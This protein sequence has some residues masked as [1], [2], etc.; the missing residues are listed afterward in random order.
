MAKA[1]SFVLDPVA[2]LTEELVVEFVALTCVLKVR[3]YRERGKHVVANLFTE[4]FHQ[5]FPV[6]IRAVDAY[7]QLPTGQVGTDQLSFFFTYGHATRIPVQP[8]YLF[9]FS[10]RFLRDFL[11]FLLLLVFLI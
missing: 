6:R 2:E 1:C 3:L 11:L 5:P 8:V 10:A 9:F 7:D 4:K